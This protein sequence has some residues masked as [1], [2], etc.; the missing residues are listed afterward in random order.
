M[1]ILGGLP[2][3]IALL[4]A[5]SGDPSG[6]TAPGDSDP[7]P[8]TDLNTSDGS[9]DL[10]DE[11]V[12][13]FDAVAA[14]EVPDTSVLPDVTGPDET[15][16]SEAGGETSVCTPDCE[17]KQ[18]GSD[19]C[20]GSCGDCDDGDPCNGVETCDEGSC[21][22]GQP[23][24][25]DD[26]DPCTEDTCD[27]VGGC[28]HAEHSGPCEDGNPCT[29]GETCVEGQCIGGEKVE[30]FDF[31]P[32]TD[33]VCSSS[34]G[35][36]YFPNTKPCDDGNPCTD[37]D[38][39]LDGECQPGTTNV[40][41]PCDSDLDCLEY[42]DGDLCNGVVGCVDGQCEAV[43]DS[44]VV[45]EDDNVDD[46][47]I[48]ECEADTGLCAPEPGPDGKL[49]DDGDKCTLD[50]MCVEGTCAGK[51][52][53]CNDGSLCT[54]DS[55]APEKGCIHEIIVCDDGSACTVDGCTPNSGCTFVPVNCDDG[56]FCTEDSCDP[57]TGCLHMDVVCDD[58]SACTSDGCAPNS[59]CTF[60]PVNCDDGD[61]CTDDYCDP[62]IGC[63]N[64]PINCPG[65]QEQCV[66]GACVC[67][68]DCVGKECGEDVCVGSCGSCSSGKKCVGGACL[69][70]PYVD[71][72]IVV[73]GDGAVGARNTALTVDGTVLLAGE[74]WG[75]F[76]ETSGTSWTIAEN[77][78]GLF[79]IEFDSSFE[80]LV[81]LPTGATG[82]AAFTR[83]AVFTNGNGH[84]AL[85]DGFSHGDE[86]LLGT[87][88]PTVDV[89]FNPGEIFVAALG[90]KDWVT[91][92]GGL[93]FDNQMD[94]ALGQSGEV[95]V[96]GYSDSTV[97]FDLG[98]GEIDVEDG[99]Y[100]NAFLV[101]LDPDGKYAWS[102]TVIGPSQDEGRTVALN[103][104]G[105]V[106][107]VLDTETDSLDLGGGELEAV[108]QFDT[109]FA[110]FDTDGN[111]LW[112]RRME[113]DISL[114]QQAEADHNGDF[115]L[116]GSANS[117]ADFG[118]GPLV[119][120]GADYVSFGLKLDADGNQVWSKVLGGGW[121]GGA[122]TFSEMY[123][124]SAAVGEDNS[125]YIGAAF[126]GE[127]NLGGGPMGT[128]EGGGGVVAKLDADGE[129]IWS[130]YVSDWVHSVAAGPDGRVYATTHFGEELVVGDQAFPNEGEGV[131]PFNGKPWT[132]TALIVLSE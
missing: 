19:G 71:D 64:E 109:V 110:S 123:V 85:C 9:S 61:P 111:H 128:P 87:D 124:F 131:N 22:T 94:V 95:F 32:C 35:C 10:G 46:C 24:D 120:N 127:H 21:L 119:D 132:N 121:G 53:N 39:C 56:T 49:C 103:N 93:S 113:W 3:L 36:L 43:P 116:I 107:W 26:G 91:A 80:P 13:G 42:D 112:S 12:E 126:S 6:G 104:D 75:S 29:K 58:D 102:K 129:H 38:Q 16:G 50:D 92:F 59:G 125:I 45:C 70:P 65:Q 69:P 82:A 100:W 83:E 105:Q 99:H 63:Q 66:E 89:E 30:C 15:T 52:A 86:L 114:A 55:C 73:A 41:F 74:A 101:K 106:F 44:L 67:L 97:D 98:G 62:T 122:G 47:V 51:P 7:R 78:K 31:N 72:V 115:V 40:C 34:Q 2:L 84:V 68:P 108:S 48:W 27:A 130:I 25:C 5:C 90:E 8:L 37:G 88:P 33:N 11:P 76:V 118:G 1:R 79:L 117:N 20:G 96:T 14:P 18:C 54:E 77:Q 28:K 60:V 23:P 17:D 81:F 4:I 57:E